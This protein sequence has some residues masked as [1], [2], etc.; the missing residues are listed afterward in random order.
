[1]SVQSFKFRATGGTTPD[2]L[3]AAL[4]DGAVLFFEPVAELVSVLFFF[5]Q[6][7]F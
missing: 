7:V 3:L 6:D 1:M 2:D 5:R 4:E